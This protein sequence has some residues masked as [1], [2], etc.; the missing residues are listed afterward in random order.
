MKKREKKRGKGRGR[1]VVVK[2]LRKNEIPD[3]FH[4]DILNS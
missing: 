1:N 2:F 3:H 4:L